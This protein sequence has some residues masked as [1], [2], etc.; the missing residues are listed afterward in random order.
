[1]RGLARGNGAAEVFLQ[2]AHDNAPA[3]ALYDSLGY[4]RDDH[5]LVYTLDPRLG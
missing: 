2:T 4:T 3:R 1:V 5:Y